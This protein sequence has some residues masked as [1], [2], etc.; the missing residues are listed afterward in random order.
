MQ[1]GHNN[2]G[3]NLDQGDSATITYYV[4]F[5]KGGEDEATDLANE[6]QKE[7]ES[8]QAVSPVGRLTVTWG[9]IRA[10]H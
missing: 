3:T 8:G 7:P 10:G 5:G 2:L 4:A 1:L 9:Q 6:V